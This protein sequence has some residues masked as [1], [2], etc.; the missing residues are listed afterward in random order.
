MPKTQFGLGLWGNVLEAVQKIFWNDLYKNPAYNIVGSFFF[1]HWFVK[2]TKIGKV[3]RWINFNRGDKV[4]EQSLRRWQ[5]STKGQWKVN[6]CAL[7]TVMKCRAILFNTFVIWHLDV[8]LALIQC[9]SEGREGW[10]DGGVGGFGKG[11][12]GKK[13]KWKTINEWRSKHNCNKKGL[14]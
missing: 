4:I 13:F 14:L 11:I 5:G 10:R 8:Q 7:K 9:K 12:N 3:L 6:E 1:S 2:E